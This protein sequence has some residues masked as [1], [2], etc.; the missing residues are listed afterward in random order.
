[1]DYGTQ[2]M[3]A[4]APGAVLVAGDERHVFALW[5]FRTVP[6]RRMDVS[7][8]ATGLVGYDW[9]REQVARAQPELALPDSVATPGGWAEYLRA[10][11]S[12]RPVYLADPDAELMRALTVTTEGPLWRV[13]GSGH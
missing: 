5:Y 1:M 10:L 4:A 2:V 8:V 6:Q 12:Q 9:Y 7:V 3:D 11:A 13:S